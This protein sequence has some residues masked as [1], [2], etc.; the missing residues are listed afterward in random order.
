MEMFSHIYLIKIIAASF[1]FEKYKALN[2]QTPFNVNNYRI[3]LDHLSSIYDYFTSMS[4]A[5]RIALDNMMKY[6]QKHSD[7]AVLFKLGDAKSYSTYFG[8]L[9]DN[10]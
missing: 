5:M 4:G 3:S 9:F 2:K 10:N 6:A 8:T 1:A 7:K